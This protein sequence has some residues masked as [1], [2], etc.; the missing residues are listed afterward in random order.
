VQKKTPKSRFHWKILTRYL[1]FSG[2]HELRPGGW[3]ER[4][5]MIKPASA[6]PG[7]RTPN[8]QIKSLLL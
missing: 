7:T 3:Y 5:R 2:G 1:P 8:P 6:P 4:A